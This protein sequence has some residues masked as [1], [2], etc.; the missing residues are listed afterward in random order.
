MP[1]HLTLVKMAARIRSGKL[2]A[3]ELVEAHLWQIERHNPRVNAF[4]TVFADQARAEALRADEQRK[5]GVAR[6]PSRQTSV[7]HIATIHS[8]ARANRARVPVLGPRY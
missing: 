7:P 4:V 2:S 1:N 8:K 5:R 3:V 6:N